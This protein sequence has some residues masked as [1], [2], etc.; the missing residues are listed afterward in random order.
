MSSQETTQT[1]QSID[2]TELEKPIQ[3]IITLVEKLDEK[4]RQK[5]FEVLLDFYLH[6]EFQL[7]TK[8]KPTVE[9][10]EPKGEKEF[11]I[12][13][14]VRAFLQTYEVPEETV[15]KLFLIEKNETRPIY[16]ITTTKKSEAQIQ[17]ALLAALE[18]AVQ[19]QG[20]KFEFSIEKVREQCQ[21]HKVYDLA[22]FRAYFKNNI[23][24]FKSLDDEEHVEL[25]PEGQT[26]LAEV[27]NIVAK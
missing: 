18:N 21:K 4:Y 27:M 19:K 1:K 20:N 5:C 3:E 15:G 26:E 2:F 11:I 7:A 17:L 12:P 16:K 6:K 14:D 9:P 25:S 24:L 23:K 10:E 22:N 8:P 13:I